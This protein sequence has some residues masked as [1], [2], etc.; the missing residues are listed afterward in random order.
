[1]ARRPLSQ[2]Q[3]N[4]VRAVA[5]A[6]ADE[7]SAE[8]IAKIEA[9]R[10]VEDRIAE[11]RKKTNA[12]MFA[13]RNNHGVSIAVLTEMVLGNTN[14]KGVTDRLEEHAALF[15]TDELRDRM[16]PAPET[17]EHAAATVGLDVKRTKD[18]I[19]VTFTD[20]T[21][22]DLGN[23]VT[24]ILVFDLDGSVIEAPSGESLNTSNPLLSMLVWG[25]PEV[26]AVV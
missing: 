2:E 9:Q 13:A 25:M 12:L 15:D 5:Q 11:K 7:R 26:Q 21:H 19:V 22:P 10:I 20:F 3:N 6:I 4:V 24:G 17:A 1:M 14:R 8:A 23:G 16:A 18:M